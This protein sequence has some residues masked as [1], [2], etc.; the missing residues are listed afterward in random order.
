MPCTHRRS[1]RP[2]ALRQGRL[3]PGRAAAPGEPRLALL[4]SGPDAVHVSPLRGTRSS[5]PSR[6]A[7]FED[8]DLGWEFSPAGADCR[9][10]APLVPRLARH[11]DHSRGTRRGGGEG[12]IRTLD[13]L[14]HTAFPV[15]RPRPLGDL[16]AGDRRGPGRCATWADGS[17][18]EWRR[19]WDS[20]PR[21]LRTPLFESGTI[22]H[23]D[24][25]P[26]GRIA[27]RGP[28]R[29][30]RAPAAGWPSSGPPT[31]RRGQ[32]R[33]SAAASWSSAAS[34]RRIPLMRSTR[35]GRAGLLASWTTEPAAPDT[36]SGRA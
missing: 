32:A 35:R 11:H 28:D 6:S 23:S 14:P 12:G 17:G 13:G 24:T 27:K 29:E 31:G 33:R 16:S 18:S 2:R 21:C 34:A 20:N 22:N 9:Y 15:R 25:S 36:G 1:A 4:P 26:P 3:R 10:R 19:G 5:A 8:V 7:A 30:I